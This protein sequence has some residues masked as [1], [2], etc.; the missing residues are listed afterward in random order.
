MNIFTRN[1]L[2]Q[3]AT[4]ATDS[5]EARIGIRGTGT[6]LLNVGYSI[7]HKLI[8]T[9]RENA[10]ATSGDEADVSSVG[11][12]ETSLHSDEDHGNRNQTD[13]ELAAALHYIWTL[14]QTKRENRLSSRRMLLE[15]ASSSRRT[16]YSQNHSRQASVAGENTP[17]VS[18]IYKN[19]LRILGLSVVFDYSRVSRYQMVNTSVIEESNADE[20]DNI[21]HHNESDKNQI[22]FDDEEP[23]SSWDHL[24]MILFGKGIVSW[25]MLAMPLSL[26]AVFHR[27]SD[28]WIFW[29]F[30]THSSGRLP[31]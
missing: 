21:K 24:L 14:K 2:D 12:E 6:S 15:R 11:G 7:V 17:L 26:F 22:N 3:T 30:G 13:D 8:P 23:M 9:A 27:W 16:V 20:E 25:C 29:L 28:T 5:N 10:M 31:W 1:Q 4:S 18:K 19:V